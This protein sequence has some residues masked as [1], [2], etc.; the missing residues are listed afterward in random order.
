MSNDFSNSETADPTTHLGDRFSHVEVLGRGA[1]GTVYKV[2]DKNT[3]QTVALKILS[4]HE[5]F[6]DHAE[7]RFDSEMQVCIA[8]N[9]PNLVKAYEAVRIRHHVGFTMELIDGSNLLDYISGK[10]CNSAEIDRIMTQLLDGLAVLHEAKIIHRDIKLENIMIQADGTVK[11]SDL[12]LLKN[13]EGEGLT[14]PGIILGTPMYMAPEYIKTGK[15]D[16]RSDIYACGVILYELVSGKRR[17]IENNDVNEFKYLL[18]S[19]FEF[20]RL[21]VSGDHS[22]YLSVLG[23][24]LSLNPGARYQSAGEMRQAIL[25]SKASLKSLTRNLSVKP[26]IAKTILATDRRKLFLAAATL[27]LLIFLSLATTYFFFKIFW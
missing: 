20:P 5:G 24:A 13:L 6:Q 19:N 4:Q 22:K 2:Y 26:G 25:D 21:D 27:A 15:F 10:K 17:E 7:E 14:K 3:N 12:G 1:S 8:L 16:H 18:Q 11:L 23:K 9:H